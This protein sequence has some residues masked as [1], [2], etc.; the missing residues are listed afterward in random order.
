MLAPPG[1][2][3][4]TSTPSRSSAATR[5]SAPFIVS[6]LSG[7]GCGTLA[8]SRV[9]EVFIDRVVHYT[10]LMP[11]GQLVENGRGEDGT[12]GTYR[13]WDLLS[14]PFSRAANVLAH[15]AMLQKVLF[16]AAEIL[17]LTAVFVPH[18]EFSSSKKISVVAK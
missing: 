10:G 18:P 12:I 3:K 7:L 11:V 13:T 4:I 16:E 15:V 6:P 14:A 1:Y 5:I 17:R 2:A 8:D 9:V